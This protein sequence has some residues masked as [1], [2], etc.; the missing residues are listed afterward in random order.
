MSATPTPAEIRVYL[1]AMEKLSD[2]EISHRHTRGWGAF[3][4]ASLPIP[5]AVTVKAWLETM[6]APAGDVTPVGTP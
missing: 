4:P 1:D 5:E 3:D 6:A 2:F